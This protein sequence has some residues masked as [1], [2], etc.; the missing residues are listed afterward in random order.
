[1][2]I[3]LSNVEDCMYIYTE[4]TIGNLQLPMLETKSMVEK[5]N[6]NVQNILPILSYS[7]TVVYNMLSYYSYFSSGLWILSFLQ[8]VLFLLMNMKNVRELTRGWE[9]DDSKW[10]HWVNDMTIRLGIPG[11]DRVEPNRTMSLIPGNVLTVTLL[12]FRSFCMTYVWRALSIIEAVNPVFMAK[13][14]KG[15][16]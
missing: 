12:N 9:E 10:T 2:W 14:G 4:H 8:F 1:M 13:G 5:R 3:E 6:A 15:T 16:V 7:I 11:V